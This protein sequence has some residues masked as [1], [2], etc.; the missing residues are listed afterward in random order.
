M[1][2]SAVSIIFSAI[3]LAGDLKF[4][5]SPISPAIHCEGGKV[6]QSCGPHVQPTCGSFEIPEIS[7]ENNCEEGCFCPIGKVLH[8]GHCI[9]KSECPCQWGNRAYASG[10]K[11]RKGCNSWLAK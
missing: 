5:N 7:N 3:F 6:Y 10:K 11:I 4:L 9:Q 1:F 2:L 8:D